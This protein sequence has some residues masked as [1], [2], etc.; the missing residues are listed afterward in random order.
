MNKLVEHL[1]VV[2]H[3]TVPTIINSSFSK[4]WHRITAKEEMESVIERASMWGLVGDHNVDH[5][6]STKLGGKMRAKR[7]SEIIISEK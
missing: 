2:Q 5:S 7:T 4:V 6:V 1:Q 3:S